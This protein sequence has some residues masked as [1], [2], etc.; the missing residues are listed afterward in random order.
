MLLALDFEQQFK[1]R[2][3]VN[4]VCQFMTASIQ[5]KHPR[6]WKARQRAT[7]YKLWDLARALL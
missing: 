2:L 5:L 6:R 3:S 4:Q 1:S 7:K